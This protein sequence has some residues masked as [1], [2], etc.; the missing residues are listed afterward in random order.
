MY[1]LTFT[2]EIFAKS[3]TTLIFP[4]SR[5]GLRSFIALWGKYL[6]KENI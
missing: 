1:V 6:A 2:R 3:S 4:R 5:E